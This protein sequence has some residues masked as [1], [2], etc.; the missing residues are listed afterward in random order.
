MKHL[1]KG[2]KKEQRQRERD[3]PSPSQKNKP[4][5]RSQWDTYIRGTHYHMCI[6]RHGNP[7]LNKHIFRLNLL[8][9]HTYLPPSKKGAKKLGFTFYIG[10]QVP[11]TLKNIISKALI[12][13]NF[14]IHQLQLPM[15]S[16][17]RAFNF[18]GVKKAH[19][20]SH[21]LLLTSHGSINNNSFPWI[22]R[23]G[24]KQRYKITL[25]MSGFC[26]IPP[27]ISL[28]FCSYLSP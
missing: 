12:S 20:H 10:S 16:V 6:Q 23:I 25:P 11:T 22:L 21:S 17:H 18:V 2:E 26:A 27:N 9:H 28:C 4:Q 13:N 24:T 8:L 1:A 19:T 5:S 14:F 3:D 7:L 15:I